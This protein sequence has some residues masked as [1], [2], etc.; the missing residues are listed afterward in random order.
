MAI[1]A[2]LLTG[3]LIGGILYRVRWQYSSIGISISHLNY[4]TRYRRPTYVMRKRE[5][6]IVLL[7]ESLNEFKSNLKTYLFN[8]PQQ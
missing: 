3:P 4:W 5:S 1:G 2:G 8:L 6:T 7:N